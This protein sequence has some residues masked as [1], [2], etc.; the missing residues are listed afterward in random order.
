MHS[1]AQRPGFSYVLKGILTENVAGGEAAECGPG[2]VITEP[3]E[4]TYSVANHGREPVEL[5]TVR[6]KK[7]R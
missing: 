7:K 4:V 5:L 3:R 1:H 6:V 2:T